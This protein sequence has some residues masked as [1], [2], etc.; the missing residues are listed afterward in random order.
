M[1]RISWADLNKTAAN[2]YKNQK[3]ETP[4]GQAFDSV[5]EYNRFCELRLLQRAGEIKDLQTQVKFVLIPAQCEPDTVGPRG[6]IRKGKTIEQECSYLAD[7]VYFTKDG[8]KVVE[9]AKGCKTK[10]YLIKRKLM[11]YVHGIR[12]QEI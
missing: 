5:R 8:K 1:T 4:D 9:D 10:E 2:K 11:L 12:I 3:I 7:F 6:G